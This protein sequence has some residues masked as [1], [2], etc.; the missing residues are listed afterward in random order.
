MVEDEDWRRLVLN[1]PE[2]VHSLIDCLCIS[3]DSSGMIVKEASH[4]LSVIGRLFICYWLKLCFCSVF[5]Q[6]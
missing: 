3:D 6:E 1:E 4:A 2:L 5:S